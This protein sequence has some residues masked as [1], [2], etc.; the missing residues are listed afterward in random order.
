MIVPVCP[1]TG[2]ELNGK[3]VAYALVDADMKKHCPIIHRIN[4]VSEKALRQMGYESILLEYGPTYPKKPDSSIK[5][6]Q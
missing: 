4:L 2:R 6:R 1:V 5:K 3:I